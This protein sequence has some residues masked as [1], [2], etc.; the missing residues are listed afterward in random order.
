M[1]DVAHPCDTGLSPRNCSGF[2]DPSRVALQLRVGLEDRRMNE[3][4]PVS[5]LFSIHDTRMT[6]HRASLRSRYP[7]DD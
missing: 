2:D 5:N 4:P 3:L 1:I 6:W 7:Q